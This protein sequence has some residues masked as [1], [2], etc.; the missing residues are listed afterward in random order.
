[1]PSRAWP[2]RMGKTMILKKFCRDHPKVVDRTLGLAR[3]PVV[4]MQLPPE[5]VEVPFYEELLGALGLPLVGEVSR[6]RARRMVRDAL[7]IIGARMLIIDEMEADLKTNELIDPIEFAAATKIADGNDSVVYK[8][9]DQAVKKYKMLGFQQIVDYSALV[10]RSAE[11]LANIEYSGSL[12]IFDTAYKI[13]YVGF[14]VDQVTTADDGHPL[15]LQ[16]FVPGPNLDK[17]LQP[18]RAFDKYPL[19]EVAEATHREFFVSLNRHFNREMPTRTRDQFEY[20]LAMLSRMID[21]RLD[22]FGIYISKYNVKFAL[23]LPGR[24]VTFLI[25]D[26]AL[27]IDHLDYHK[28]RQP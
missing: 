8:M 2:D 22:V 16:K 11:I 25:T 24:E 4:M 13:C 18:E 7:R 6:I 27:Y 12:H 1:M 14:K 3:T 17:L 19:H 23:N 28:Q 26:I 21:Y 9:R 15:A 5:P 10:N 20:H